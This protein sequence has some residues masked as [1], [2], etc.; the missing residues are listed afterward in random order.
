MIIIWYN[1]SGDLMNYSMFSESKHLVEKK[2]KSVLSGLSSKYEVDKVVYNGN[3]KEFNISTLLNDLNT[4]P[5]LSDH[6]VII[7]ENPFFFSSKA[8]LSD[9]END[10][11]ISYLKN[12]APF[13]TLIIY[14][15]SFKV[16]KRKKIVKETIKLTK[17]YQPQELNEY[18]YSNI[19]RDD[20]H[21]AAIKIDQDAFLELVKR[22]SH[23]FDG[24]DNEFDKLSL[25]NKPYLQ[26]SDIDVLISKPN[27]DN[28]FDL[29]NAVV[30]KNLSES[31][32]VWRNFPK[33]VREP[34]S[35]IM[36][37]ASQFRLIH[38]VITLSDNGFRYNDLASELKVHPYRVKM[39]NQIARKT[40]SNEALLVLKQLSILEQSIKQGR[41]IPEI[42][43]ELFLIEVCN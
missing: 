10:L 42:G 36:L 8:G 43:F 5:F 27:L 15:N 20:L 4:M 35:M 30:A 21:K 25:Y 22:V 1:V 29:V 14:I 7:L 26:Y 32:H 13:S 6:K 19:I 3:D 33:D 24:W 18:E 41:V 23:N 28:V 2:L 16:D 9:N 37:L 11:L 17:T 38:Q 12:P 39:A 31:L 34:I 40:S